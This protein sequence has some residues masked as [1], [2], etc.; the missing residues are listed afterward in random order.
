MSDGWSKRKPKKKFK[1]GDRVK[2]SKEYINA[3]PNDHSHKESVEFYGSGTF[4]V[5]FS[6]IEPGGEIDSGDEGR[7][8]GSEWVKIYK[9]V[10]GKKYYETW[11]R[12]GDRSWTEWDSGQFNTVGG[13]M[14]TKV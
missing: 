11:H 14:L 2:I 3:Y 5:E 7:W 10:N 1:P 8:W 9:V 6:M 13:W 12:N 4:I